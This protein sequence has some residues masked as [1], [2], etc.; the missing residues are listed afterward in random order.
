MFIT[1]ADAD[2]E[3]MKKPKKIAKQELKE[4]L[5]EDK[6]DGETL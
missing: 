6:N 1:L 4:Y 5:H 2:T 3:N